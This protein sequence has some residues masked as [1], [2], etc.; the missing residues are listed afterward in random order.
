MEALHFDEREE[1][2]LEVALHVRLREVE[3]GELAVAVA[4]VAG[5]GAHV[6]LPVGLDVLEHTSAWPILS[7]ALL[8]DEV[9]SLQAS[10][11]FGAWSELWH[12]RGQMAGQAQVSE[13]SCAV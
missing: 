1:R 6:E 4:V 7:T 13:A 9:Q 11:M 3:V 5:A 12:S 8:P 2:L 10:V